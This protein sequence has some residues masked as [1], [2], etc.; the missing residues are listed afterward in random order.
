MGQA[1]WRHRRG[2]LAVLTS[3]ALTMPLAL[4]GCTSGTAGAKAAKISPAGGT[5]VVSSGVRVHVAVGTAPG[6]TI[7]DRAV[8]DPPAYPGNAAVPVGPAVDIVPSG[9]LAAST[10]LMS[11]NPATDL[12]RA[13]PGAAAPTV[14]NAFIA[15]LDQ[16][17]GTWVPLATSYD[18][19]THRLAAVAPHF[20]IFRIFVTTPGRY[21]Y[22]AAGAAVSVVVKAGESGLRVAESVAAG[23]WDSVRP[24]F[25]FRRSLPANE[26][27]A[28]TCTG[29]DPRLPWDTTYGIYVSDENMHVSS[30]VVDQDARPD[31]P[32]LLMEN[33][34][35]FPVDVMPQ[36]K[37]AVL[38][39]LSMG[40]HPDQD[41]VAA[42]NSLLGF[43][44]IPGPGVTQIRLPSGTPPVFYVKVHADWLGLAT[45]I[46]MTAA[47]IIPGFEAETSRF[48]AQLQ[49]VITTEEN[50]GQVIRSQSQVLKIVQTKLKAEKGPALEGTDNLAS[51]YVC[52]ADLSSVSL[53]DSIRDLAGKVTGC[54][55]ELVGKPGDAVAAGG[56]TTE[57]LSYLDAVLGF[58]K[59]PAVLNDF[60]EHGRQTFIIDAVQKLDQT[61]T[62]FIRQLNPQAGT[63]SF[64]QV[65][66][67]TGAS[68]QQVC[69]EWHV[70]PEAEWCNDYYIQDLTEVRTLPVSGSVTVSAED[71]PGPVNTPVS[72]S[73]LAQLVRQPGGSGQLYQFT[74]TGGQITDITAIFRP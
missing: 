3:A 7:R 58:I 23:V 67:F 29:S 28:D 4:A 30:C 68:A 48:S 26:R 15:V 37:G 57:Y 49:N 36:E 56:I 42:L 46:I 69:A 54:L 34:Y 5:V 66:W 71:P 25:G 64:D 14:G 6:T 55:K 43:G 31:R 19:A 63:L 62:G 33:D 60:R 73:R 9:P 59:L 20:S 10:V 27:I 40:E 8:P 35:G 47:A 52:F 22:H 21:L 32:A 2:I 44:Y 74:V 17:T 65:L 39:A 16:Q 12:P 24:D 41:A 1:K 11:F 53:S 45:D 13:R 61:Y 70:T 51:A 18:A 72:L 50:E 38:P